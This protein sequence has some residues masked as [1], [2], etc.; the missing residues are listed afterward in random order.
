M[1]YVIKLAI[2]RTISKMLLLTIT[3]NIIKI[4]VTFIIRNVQKEYLH[5]KIPFVVIIVEKIIKFYIVTTFIYLMYLLEP[6]L[7]FI[8]FFNVCNITETCLQSVFNPGE[9]DF[10]TSTDKDSRQIK[11]YFRCF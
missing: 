5:K 9:L 2:I 7:S 6:K 11:V 8:H 1:M 3:L 4:K 10:L